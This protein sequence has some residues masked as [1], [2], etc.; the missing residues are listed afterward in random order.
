M[1]KRPFLLFYIAF[2][3][4]LPSTL[5]AKDVEILVSMGA[6]WPPYMI[7]DN[8]GEDLKRGGILIDI[9]NE[10]VA[11]SPYRVKV[12]TYPEKRGIKLLDKG[13]IDF[14]FDGLNW[15]EQPERFFWTDPIMDSEDVLVFVKNKSFMYEGVPKLAGKTIITLLGYTYPTFESFFKQTLIERIDAPSHL[16]MIEMLYVSRGDAAIMNK[17][18]ALWVIKKTDRFNVQNFEFSKPVDVSQIALL[19]LDKKW[20]PFIKYFNHELSILKSSGKIST[21]VKKYQ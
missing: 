9:F 19:C 1:I 8:S 18:V 17:N 5:F 7:V 2:F 6:G 3:I 15:V 16:S 21:I 11:G 20:I 13:L 4:Y 12:V 10:I 14:R